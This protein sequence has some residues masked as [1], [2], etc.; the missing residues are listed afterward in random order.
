M[1][2]D[3]THCPIF[4]PNHPTLSVDPRYYSHKFNRAGLSYEIA[5]SLVEDRIVWVS[6]P[7]PA[8]TNDIT[9]FRRGLLHHIPNGKRVI[10]DRGYMGEPDYVSTPNNYDDEIVKGFK[11]RARSR[12]ESINA[13]IKVFRCLTQC[14]RHSIEFHGSAFDA[15]CV[16]VQYQLENGSDLM[17]LVDQENVA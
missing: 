5:L 14:F 15:I 17:H 9:I 4:E 7:Y 12:Q 2:V 16:I 13:K 3:G 1:S 10:A 8:G 6:G 11:S